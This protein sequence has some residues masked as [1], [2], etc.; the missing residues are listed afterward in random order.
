MSKIS[1]LPQAD[2]LNGSEEVALV[3]NG[4]TRRSNLLDYVEGSIGPFVAAAETAA[5]FAEEF[6]GPAFITVEEG[7]EVTTVGHFFRVPVPGTDPVEYTR[8]QRTAGGS[9]V[10]A[11][12]AT[13]QALGGEDGD[14]RVGSKQAGAGAI[15]RTLQD[16][17]RERQ[18]VAGRDTLANAAALGLPVLFNAGSRTVQEGTALS[19]GTHF[20]GDG[21]TATITTV[22]ASA[23]VPNLYGFSVETNSALTDQSFIL[24]KNALNWAAAIG[25]A[26]PASN[27]TVARVNVSSA[28]VADGTFGLY[29][30][31]ADVFDVTIDGA[32]FEGIALPQIKSN[33]DESVQ[34]RWRFKNYR[35]YG[36]ID[37]FNINT[38]KGEW[39]HGSIDGHVEGST[40]FGYAFAGPG[41]FGWTGT[42][43]GS[44]N[45]FEMVHIEDAANRLHFR[46]LGERNNLEPGTAGSPGSANA[47]VS[48]IGGSNAI[49]LGLCLDIAQNIG[50][51]PAGVAIQAGGPRVSDGLTVDPYNIKIG[52][53]VKGGNG[54]VAVIAIEA[55]DRIILDHLSAESEP[56]DVMDPCLAIPGSNLGGELFIKTPGVILEANDN[57]SMTG[58]DTLSLTEV[59]S[60][61][62]AWCEGTTTDRT[63]IHITQLLKLTRAFTADVSATWQPVMPV[64]R[65]C[66]VK[67]GWKFHQNGA[68]NGAMMF[69]DE[70]IIKGGAL[71]PTPVEVRAGGS[72]DPIPGHPAAVTPTGD[73]ENGKFIVNNLSS[74]TG[75][76][77]GHDITGTGIAP[78][79]KVLTILSANSLCLDKP[80]TGTGAGASLSIRIPPMSDLCWRVN[81][82]MLECKMYNISTAAGILSV[83]MMGLMTA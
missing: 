58:L 45:N 83:V 13:T 73:T 19:T 1:K 53:N 72:T 56:G 39:S 66:R 25:F 49:T 17:S 63:A 32:V 16:V 42:L 24:D 57:T 28:D 54:R 10:V 47:T 44:D 9:V 11:P 80:M 23:P 7:E 65:D 48:I 6:S 2:L 36:C 27:I 37:G 22:Q 69:C 30:D 60:D 70:F 64:F 21:E 18:S 33:G 3:Q 50:G 8:Y 71:V 29:I 43:R 15:L 51:S 35:A 12:L 75:I 26:S 78:D 74:L 40:Q 68:S 5:G 77:P 81:S 31:G 55:T 62:T 20:F 34:K 38:P 61:F 41:C 76:A 79:T 52:G 59:T 14:Q 67:A 82:G 4:K 46:V